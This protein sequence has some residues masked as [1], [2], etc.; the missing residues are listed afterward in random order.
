MNTRQFSAGNITREQRRQF[1]GV[2]LRR[3]EREHARAALCAAERI[4]DTVVASSRMVRGA[5]AIC[6]DAAAIIAE[7]CMRAAECVADGIIALVESAL[8]HHGRHG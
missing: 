7:T 6:M 8:P 3:F 5:G 2:Q 4:V 1:D